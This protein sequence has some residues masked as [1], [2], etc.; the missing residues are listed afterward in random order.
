MV[1]EIAR[2]FEID[3][4]AL[5]ALI[6][7]ERPAREQAAADR[8]AFLERLARQ[9]LAIERELQETL[10]LP[11]SRHV[12]VGKHSCKCADARCG[13]CRRLHSGPGGACKRCRCRGFL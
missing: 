7:A 4:F 13:H 10:S 2:I 5:R 6:E 1:S 3:E 9:R 12:H 11:S 8:K